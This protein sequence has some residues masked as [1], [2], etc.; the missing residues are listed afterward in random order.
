MGHFATE[1]G[2]VSATINHQADK[3]LESRFQH[4]L[5]D[6]ARGMQRN[7]IREILKV[8][9][10][11]GMISLAGGIPAAE[12]FPIEELYRIN[13]SVLN[14][15]GAAALQY[16]LTEGF[17]PFRAALA[18]FLT[19]KGIDA[20]AEQLLVFNGS[21]S[22]LDT[23]GKILITPGDVIALESPSYLGA[24]SAFSS[25]QPEYV[26]IET[27]DDG[28]VP[29]SL[30][31]VLDTQEVTFVYLVTTFQNPTGRTL[32]LQ[33]RHEIAEIIRDRNVLVI[34]DDPYSDLRYRGEAVPPLHSLAPENTVYVSTL[35]KIFAPGLRLGFC[36]APPQIR[37]WLYVAKQAADLH[38][39][40]YAQAL[41][42]EYICGGYIE[43]QIPKIIDLYRPRQEVMLNAMAQHFPQEF[44]W[45][46]PEGGMFIW[47]EGPPGVDA[48]QIYWRAIEQ[49]V[50]FVPG[51]YFFINPDD[52]L[53]TMRLNFTRA[54]EATIESAIATLGSVLQE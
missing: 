32:S 26:S 19:N 40:T 50:A 31:R 51:K 11:P 27:D 42:T 17:Q 3:P 44:R 18:G 25:Y 30:M 15:Y 33:R 29:E 10:Q 21:Q 46:A 36:L 12:T 13:E 37:E 8:V 5:S 48:E 24:I 20:D 14:R 2:E 28:I 39:N 6:R 53:R 22:V 41:A 47:V 43:R 16:D 35:S 1:T 34:E 4:L 45:T 52:G 54:D 23:V 38:S 49:K 9:A 7:P